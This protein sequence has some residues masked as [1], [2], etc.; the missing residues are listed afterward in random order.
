[1]AKIIFLSLFLFFNSG[2]AFAAFQA[3]KYIDEKVG[4]ANRLKDEVIMYS[5]NCRSI[6]EY[7]VTSE[8]GS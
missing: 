8:K 1:M 5:A 2:C 4:E 7:P 6:G 3:L